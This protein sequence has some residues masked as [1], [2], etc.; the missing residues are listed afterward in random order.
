MAILDAGHCRSLA[1]EERLM[2][3][4]ERRRA[5][6]NLLCRWLHERAAAIHE[7]AA[8]LHDRMADLC[9]ARS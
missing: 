1:V 8:V 4:T 2:A 6:A 3:Q 9:E 5:A 7:R